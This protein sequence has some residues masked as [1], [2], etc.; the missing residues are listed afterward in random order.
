MLN[1]FYRVLDNKKGFTLI[2]VLV[3]VA[4]I[5]ILAALAAPS[6]LGRIEQSRAASDE[7]LAKTL[8]NAIA[9]WIV[10]QDL[11]GA[12]VK[13]P[14]SL[15]YLIYETQL[16]SDGDLII[17]SDA[18]TVTKYLDN[19][20][21]SFLNDTSV[22][23]SDESGVSDA[24]TE[25]DY[26][27]SELAKVYFHDDTDWEVRSV[28]QGRVLTIIYEVNETKNEYNLAVLDDRVEDVPA[29]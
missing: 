15:E 13:F 20:T 10:D 26:S 14:A 18:S 5:G 22:M 2:E 24:I 23:T 4:I 28:I 11:L 25:T 9:A 17:P 12:K 27:E 1:W 7:A 19:S 29:S 3:V 16:D 8:D 21:V 6:I